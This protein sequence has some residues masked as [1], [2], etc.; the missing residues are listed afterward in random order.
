MLALDT[1]GKLNDFPI[2]VAVSKVDKTKIINELREK[3]RKRSAGIASR[4]RIKS[5][6]L[7]DEELEWF[8]NRID[9]P[10]KAVEC[11]SLQYRTFK[12]HENL[13]DFRHAEMLRFSCILYQQRK[14]WKFEFLSLLYYAG[15]SGMAKSD[16]E[17]LIDK[18]Y[19]SVSMQFIE[20]MLKDLMLKWNNIHVKISIAEKDDAIVAADLIAGAARRG[21]ISSVKANVIESAIRFYKK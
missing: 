5:S 18:D 4:R 2:V 8:I 6:D 19:D 9:F 7:T 16:E 12:L 21:L 1:S 13:T 14:K 11:D 10:F 20:V 15:I 3:V 17:I